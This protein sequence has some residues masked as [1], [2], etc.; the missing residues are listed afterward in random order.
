M[1]VS[2]VGYLAAAVC[3]IAS[4]IQPCRAQSGPNSV[5]LRPSTPAEIQ[6][7]PKFTFL[8]FYKENNANTQRITAELTAALAQRADRAEW[9]AVSINDA[10]NRAIV[11]TLSTGPGPHAAGAVR[12]AE[13]CHYRRDAGPSDRQATSRRHSLRRQ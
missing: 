3:S 11:E 2:I 5:A 7:E 8:L 12:R 4:M 1:R 10:A 13:R 9:Q 6:A